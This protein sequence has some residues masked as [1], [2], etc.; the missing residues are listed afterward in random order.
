MPPAPPV[1]GGPQ[2]TTTIL[3]ARFD[4]V[5][6]TGSSKVAR[7][8]AAAAAKHLTPTTLELGGQCPAIVT[9]T[10]NVE[11][12]A[13]RIAYIKFLSAG[14]ICL[15]VNHV[16]VDPGVHDEFLRHLT[17]WTTQFGASGHMCR[18][19]NQRNYDRL[20]QLLENTNGKVICGGKGSREHIQLASTVLAD[21]HLSGTFAAKGCV[22]SRTMAMY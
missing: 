2:E 14:Q 11:L 1:T 21:I 3:E 22:D 13:K 7:F 18:V 4:H 19:I 15:S 20:V 6:F 12:A 8:V 16:L 10:A 17:R 5:F 9:K